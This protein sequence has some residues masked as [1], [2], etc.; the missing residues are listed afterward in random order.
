MPVWPKQSYEELSAFYGDPDA[1][2]DGVPDRKWEDA[3]L[4]GITPPYQMV[5]AWAPDT[6][7]KTIRVHRKASESLAAVLADI[8][9]HYGSQQAIEAARM[10]LYGGCYQF[11]PMRG[12]ARLSVHSWGCAIDLDPARNSLG[13]VPRIDRAVVAIFQKHGWVWGG[14]WTRKDGMHFQAATV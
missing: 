9:A 2:S 11:R 8:L 13:A 5:L 1:N 10:H 6:K 12:A 3:N 4:I 14:N 7:L